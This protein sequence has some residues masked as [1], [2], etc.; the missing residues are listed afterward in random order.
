MGW[1]QGVQRNECSGMGAVRW[2]QEGGCREVLRGVGSEVW[3]QGVG[4]RG[5]RA[6]GSQT[7]NHASHSPALAVHMAIGLLILHASRKWTT[8]VHSVVLLY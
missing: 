3:V 5:R 4:C 2:M 8:K 1:V 7:S 6:E